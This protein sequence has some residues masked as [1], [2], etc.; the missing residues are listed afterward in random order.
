VRRLG[1]GPLVALTVG[2]GPSRQ[3]KALLPSPRGQG[4]EVSNRL[5]ARA[6]HIGLPADEVHESGNRLSATRLLS[7]Q[8]GACIPA[9][10]ISDHDLGARKA[11][12]QAAQKNVELRPRYRTD[13]HQCDDFGRLVG[14]R[15]GGRAYARQPTERRAA[16]IDTALEADGIGDQP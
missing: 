9:V 6:A 8:V 16:G 2:F 1:F 13:G 11:A 5:F 10:P 15:L 14:P 7:D 4:F 3:K 12:S